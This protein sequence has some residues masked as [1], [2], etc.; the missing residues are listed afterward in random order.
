M[1]VPYALH[2]L[3]LVI[4]VLVL[5]HQIGHFCPPVVTSSGSHNFDLFEF[6]FW[7]FC[8]YEF[9]VLLQIL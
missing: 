1:Q 5:P 2:S 6:P 4:P 7:N 9:L 3:C 8:Y